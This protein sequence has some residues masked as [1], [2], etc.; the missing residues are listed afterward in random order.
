MLHRKYYC[1]KLRAEYAVLSVNILLL[2]YKRTSI[3]HFRHVENCDEF[4]YSQQL[5]F[6]KGFERSRND[7]EDVSHSLNSVL[8]LPID[9]NSPK[10]QPIKQNHQVHFSLEEHKR[11]QF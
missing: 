4:K 11:V 10:G 9:E 2:N 1:S 7:T 3:L 5:W 8:V 6:K